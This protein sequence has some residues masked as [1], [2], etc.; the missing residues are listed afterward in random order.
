MAAITL[1]GFKQRLQRHPRGRHG[2]GA[3]PF[4]ALGTKKAALQQ[5]NTQLGALAGKL[6]SL[7]SAAARLSS[8]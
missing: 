8:P 7:Q 3:Q 1:S 6:S 5:Q 2:P 4:T